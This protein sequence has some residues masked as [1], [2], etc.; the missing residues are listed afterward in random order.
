MKRT[1][2]A[3][4]LALRGGHRPGNGLTYHLTLMDET[5]YVLEIYRNDNGKV[6][7]RQDCTS[8]RAVADYLKADQVIKSN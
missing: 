3:I 2:K 1:L 8:L 7:Y 5:R 6:V 4:D